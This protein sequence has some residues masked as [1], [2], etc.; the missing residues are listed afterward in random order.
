MSKLNYL[1]ETQRILSVYFPP[2]SGFLLLK[3]ISLYTFAVLFLLFQEHA[4]GT[5]WHNGTG[6]VPHS[7]SLC[8]GV[9]ALGGQ[10]QACLHHSSGGDQQPEAQLKCSSGMRSHWGLLHLKQLA[11]PHSLNADE[12]AA[13]Y[14]LVS[15]AGQL[16]WGRGKH[17]PGSDTLPWFFCSACSF[18]RK[19]IK[20]S[21]HWFKGKWFQDHS[22]L[23]L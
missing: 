15:R 14:R 7:S 16:H 11:L 12:A 17:S 13:L 8:L 9:R 18:W 21:P 22:L 10:T 20:K 4:S 2:F 1:R 19:N 3:W 23:N 5:T 6:T